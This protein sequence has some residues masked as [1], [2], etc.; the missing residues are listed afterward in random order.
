MR[1]G[2]MCA[3][4]L[5]VIGE[6]AGL[7]VHPLHH[8]WMMDFGTLGDEP[9]VRLCQ[10]FRPSQSTVFVTARCHDALAF[11][12]QPYDDENGDGVKNWV[13]AG[14]RYRNDWIRKTARL[15]SRL[16]DG[17]CGKLWWISKESLMKSLLRM[18]E[19]VPDVPILMWVLLPVGADCRHIPGSQLAREWREVKEALEP[20]G[21]FISPHDNLDDVSLANA[22]ADPERIHWT[23][24]M[25]LRH[26]WANTFRQA[27]WDAD[28]IDNQIDT[29]ICKWSAKPGDTW[30]IDVFAHPPFEDYNPIH[31][32]TRETNFQ[33][34]KRFLGRYHDTHG[35]GVTSEFF[36]EGYHEVCDYAWWSMFWEPIS[37]DSE[38]VP[39]LP[40]LFLG[41]A[42]MG[43]FDPSCEN[44]PKREKGHPTVGESLVWGLKFH[45]ECGKDHKKGLGYHEECLS[46]FRRIYEQNVQWRKIADKTVNNMLFRNGT[47]LPIY[48]AAN[49]RPQRK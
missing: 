6:D 31:P 35:L 18:R 4:F 8:A 49:S 23:E 40:V 48:D 44:W 17:L 9:T 41:R 32:S 24:K 45:T 37:G 5:G 28:F 26:A 47:W 13:D 38:R 22:L 10:D 34:R 39:L 16:R 2:D 36:L 11:E 42:Y 33:N 46:D 15:D 7:I 27:L 25:Q 12:L 20:Q 19:E 43:I 30:H 21:I 3:N 1:F 29:R 14:I